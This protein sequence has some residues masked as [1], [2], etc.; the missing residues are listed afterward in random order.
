MKIK[1]LSLLL[2]NKFLLDNHNFW[3]QFRK[4]L[5]LFIY[6]TED[7]L[8][9]EKTMTYWENFYTMSIEIIFPIITLRSI[10]RLLMCIWIG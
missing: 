1:Q 8:H 2:L 5:W 9:Q 6:Q 4:I 3:N 10:I 7:N